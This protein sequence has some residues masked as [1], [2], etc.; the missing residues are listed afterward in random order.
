VITAEHLRF[1]IERGR[2]L[3][4]TTAATSNYSDAVREL[5]ESIGTVSKEQYR[6]KESE[7]EILRVDLLHARDALNAHR[8][9]HRC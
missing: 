5:T 9:I 4:L 2:L 3:D 1:C 8:A 7:V 6:R